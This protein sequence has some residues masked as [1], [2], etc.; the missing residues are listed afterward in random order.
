MEETFPILDNDI[1][2]IFMETSMGTAEG[3]PVVFDGEDTPSFVSSA[4]TEPLVTDFHGFLDTG[5]FTLQTTVNT[6]FT[7]LQNISYTTISSTTTDTDS[8]LTV[9]SMHGHEDNGDINVSENIPIAKT[10]KSPVPSPES[11]T[12]P[13]KNHTSL[14]PPCRVCGEKASGFHYGAN[15]CEPCKGFFRRCIVK[16]ERNQG[17]YKCSYRGRC[18][19]SPGQ[20]NVCSACRYKKCLAVGMSKNAIKTGRYTYEKRTR[21]TNEVRKLRGIEKLEAMGQK[22]TENEMK[23]IITRLVGTQRKIHPDFP[24]IFDKKLISEKQNRAYNAYKEKEETFSA[25]PVLATEM[26]DEIYK[27]T[28]ID[29]DNRNHIKT[30]LAEWAEKLVRNMIDFMK[31]LPGASNIPVE[32]QSKLIKGSN[33]EFR[34]LVAHK[35]MNP[36]LNIIAYMTDFWIHK[37]EIQ[38]LFKNKEKV[39]ELFTMSRSFLNL[40]LSEEEV[41]LVRG[42][43]MTF[44]DRNELEK[45]EV[46]E[47]IQ[48]KLLD[49]LQWLSK[50]NKINPEQRFAKILGK[51]ISL[52]DISEMAKAANK[53]KA[54]WPAMQKY[55]LVI[56]ILSG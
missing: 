28:G 48:M 5:D 3:L 34:F 31:S 56:E 39:N 21:D 42:I 15:T 41:A 19:I 55:P 38:S 2:D 17:E 35:L 29:L 12:Q 47:Q 1:L 40:D 7:P 52:R 20:R 32:D 10:S 51:L 49:C 25:L 9:S 37:E 4:T 11:T 27:A 44:T 50:R 53:E 54:K 33:A 22:T 13:I 36:D 6:D 24:K 46:V 45:P 43:A 14:L 8:S 16:M 23:L 26:Y 18:S 30:C